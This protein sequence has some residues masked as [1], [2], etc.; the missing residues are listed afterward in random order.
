LVYLKRCEE[1]LTEEPLPDWDGVF[2]M[3]HK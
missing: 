1:F 3:T 2:V